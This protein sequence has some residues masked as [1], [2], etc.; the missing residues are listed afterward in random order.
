MR[1][2]A[3]RA[4]VSRQTVSR[5]V[6]GHPNIRETTRLRVLAAMEELQFR[7]NRAARMLSTA[8]SKTIGILTSSSSSLFGPS[9][10]IDAV[11]TAAREAGYFATVARMASLSLDEIESAVD[12][13][14][15]QAV[16]GIVVVAPQDQ[17]LDAIR[18]VAITVPF[19]T[20]HGDGGPDDHFIDQA[21]GTRLAVR[22]LIELGHTSIAHLP[23]PQ[24]WAEAVA[25][26]RAFVTETS[27]AG[28]R[29][30]VSRPGDW[31]AAS[32]ARVGAELLTDPN[33]SGAAGVTAVF[34]SNDQMAL[35]VLHALHNTGRSAPHDVSV[36]G[37]DDIPEASYFLPPL[38]TVRQDFNE[39][40]TRS[41]RLL[42]HT[43]ETG[44]PARSGSLVPPE[45]IVRASTSAPPRTH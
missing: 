28:V 19:V 5:V 13:L 20:L 38:T 43:I 32:G 27:N 11:E 29:G 22:H 12:H 26:S 30:L 35:G 25:R 1:D 36:V 41:L 14:V 23:G 42:L 45:L 3:A 10:G 7:P 31:T 37:F 8:R 15:A 2:V 9:S 21:E 44:E 34:A 6:N 24:D 16:E 39:M 18:Q 4:G 40:G 17:V 33:F